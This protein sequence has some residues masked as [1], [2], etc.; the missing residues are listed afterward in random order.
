MIRKIVAFHLALVV[1]AS[2]TATAETLLIH[3]GTL[4]AVPGEKPRSEQ[5]IVV[6]DERIMG[7][8]D[9]Y[10]SAA[11]FGSEATVVDLRDRF[12]LPGL[13]DMHVHLQH[14]LGPNRTRDMVKM[15]NQLIQMRS[16]DYAMTT[17]KAGFTT[18]RECGSSGEEMYALRDGINN[19]WI[20]GPRMPPAV[21]ALPV[22]M[23]TSAAS[24]RKSCVHG[25]KKPYAMDPTIVVGLLAMQSNLVP[26]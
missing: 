18:V 11:E 5:T 22:G 2:A 21:W 1:S 3:A 19:G 25:R 23:E 17:M 26:T 7:V 4:L 8:R 6:E 15:S 9:G 20:D 16:A 10:V 12:V 13:M 24:S 14:E